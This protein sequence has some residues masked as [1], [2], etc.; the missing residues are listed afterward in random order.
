MKNFIFESYF[1]DIEKK[2]L[3][4]NYSFDSKIC[5]SE[6]IT[7]VSDKVL[8]V[9]EIGALNNIF[10]YLHLL[11]GISYYKL[12]M[13]PNIII[14]T[15]D[16][17]KKQADFFNEFYLNGLGEFLCK[18]NIKNA[19]NIIKFPY[20]KNIIN[21]SIDLKLFDKYCVPVG[22]GKDSITSIEILKKSIDNNQIVLG[23]VNTAKSIEDTIKIAGL[24]SFLIKREISPKLME[25][26]AELDKYGA[27]NG[28][29][30]ITGILA[31]ILC[32]GAIFYKYNTVLVSNERS[33]NIGNVKFDGMFVNHQWSKS[34]RCEKM[35]NSFF[36]NYV[37]KDF[38][39]LSFL[40]P[41]SEIHIAKIFSK[42]TKYHN[43]FKSCNKN[44]K[45]NGKI[46]NW[47]C[48]CDKCRFVFL[49]LSVFLKKDKMIEIFGSNILDD[50]RH[51]NGYLELVGLKN[52]KPFECVGEI[53]ESIYAFQHINE[54]FFDSI[55]VKKIRPLILDLK[56]NKNLKLF[57]LENEHLLTN[58]LLSILINYLK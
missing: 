5:F 51:L 7:F 37:I 43:I 22:G 17:N 49:I 50:E 24:N 32:A 1:F 10:K 27:Y 56:S 9:D 23:S 18:N 39:Y 40:R 2:E 26:N 12:F 13:S 45:I 44:F 29:V 11:A 30:P 41:L 15:M 31:F 46:T 6:K 3:N 55:I 54:S 52:F 21:R 20:K 57:N 47:C 4:L 48:D 16:L 58:K 36:K 34:F 33:A 35:L 14:K 38:E 8:N 53:D 42:L 19:K 25:I 28:H